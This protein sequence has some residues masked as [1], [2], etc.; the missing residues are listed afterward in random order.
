MDPRHE[1]SSVF[2]QQHHHISGA[3]TASSTAAPGGSYHHYHTLPAIVSSGS[4]SSVL[5][6]RSHDLESPQSSSQMLGSRYQFSNSSLSPP[7]VKGKRKRAS[8]QQLEILNRVF[9]STSFPPTDMRQSLARELG[10]TPRTVQI[11]FQ[12]KRQ[13]SRQRDGNHSRNTKSMAACPGT[14]VLKGSRSMSP[15]SSHSPSPAASALPESSAPQSEQLM[16]LVAAATAS[17]APTDTRSHDHMQGRSV[18]STASGSGSSGASPSSWSDDTAVGLSASSG[19]YRFQKHDDM[20]MGSL[21]SD[22]ESKHRVESS[23]ACYTVGPPQAAP[24][25]GGRLPSIIDGKQRH[26]TGSQFAHTSRDMWFSNNTT[27]RNLEYLY[28]SGS[29]SR[30]A[31]LPLQHH[32]N[33]HSFDGPGVASRLGDSDRHLLPKCPS[34]EQR[35]SPSECM[36]AS[37]PES[38]V[39]VHRSVSLMDVLNVPPE[40]RKLPPLPPIAP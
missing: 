22:I 26:S 3:A 16:M 8:P 34:Y 9:A 19:G 5:N 27:P 29:Q 24:L 1:L 36:A 20:M 40:Q 12:N 2:D 17:T 25:V 32:N 23:S 11:W 13:A 38:S 39:P 6:H 14:G 18:P 7:L 30:S 35:T 37:P 28:G 10:M 15:A 33:Y 31:R 4:S 21:T